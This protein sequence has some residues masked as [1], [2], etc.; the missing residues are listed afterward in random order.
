MKIKFNETAC[1]DARIWLETQPDIETAWNTCKRGDWM[2]WAL[3]HLPGALPEKRI[4]VEFAN[5]C[6]DRAKT[7]AAYAAYAADAAYA[8][9]YAADAAD[10]AYAAYAAAYAAAAYAAYAAERLAQADWIREH[11][12]CPEA[13]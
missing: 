10:A 6:A 13:I 5:W 11:V 7:Y 1:E 8:A 4:L 2:W 9:A 3:Q 12:I